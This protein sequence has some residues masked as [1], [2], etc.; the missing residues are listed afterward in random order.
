MVK[1]WHNIC[2]SNSA[3]RWMYINLCWIG[4]GTGMWRLPSRADSKK[5]MPEVLT[6]LMD[7]PSSGKT[8]IS[9]YCIQPPELTH[10]LLLQHL[11]ITC[12][13]PEKT[14]GTCHS[15]CPFPPWGEHFPAFPSSLRSSWSSPTP[16]RPYLPPA[17]KLWTLG[18]FGAGTRPG[19]STRW[20]SWTSIR[21]R[22][23]RWGSAKVVASV[24]TVHPG[25]QL[26]RQF[27]D[28]CRVLWY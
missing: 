27:V 10:G 18:A 5:Y 19:S 2:G 23:P 1:S 3:N 22:H 17:W 7:I 24:S 26:N 12:S 8:G 11:D 4:F 21:R 6:V 14:P 20:S 13:E 28:H 9:H 25:L 16:P 15:Q